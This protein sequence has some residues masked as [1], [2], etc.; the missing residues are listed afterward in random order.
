[1]AAMDKAPFDL[2][3]FTIEFQLKR[4]IRTL[5]AARWPD[6]EVARQCAEAI[7][8]ALRARFEIELIVTEPEPGHSC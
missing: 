8:E 4:R 1:M 3:T 7:A 5:R 6:H 2:L